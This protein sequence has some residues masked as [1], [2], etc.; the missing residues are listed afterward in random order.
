VSALRLAALRARRKDLFTN[1]WE[2]LDQRSRLLGR[3][4]ILVD[5]GLA[6]AP[7]PERPFDPDGLGIDTRRL[8]PNHSV[9][10]AVTI[11]VCWAD[12]ESHPYPGQVVPE[13]AVLDAYGSLGGRPSPHTSA[14]LRHLLAAAG[15][16]VWVD[17]TVRLGPVVAGWGDPDIAA[18]RRVEHLLPAPFPAGIPW[19]RPTASLTVSPLTGPAPTGGRLRLLSARDQEQVL[20]AVAALENADEPLPASRFSALADPA[21]KAAVADCLAVGG[22]RLVEQPG[23]TWLSGYDDRIASRLA[24]EG[25]GVLAPVDAAVLTLVLLHTVAIPRASG[26]ASTSRW[27]DAQP[28]TIDELAKNRSLSES[29]IRVSLRRLKDAGILRP[30]HRPE[31][32][33]GPQFERLT[34][35]QSQRLW[36]DLIVT[37]KPDSPEAR[38][39][40]FRRGEIT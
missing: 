19:E 20:D 16:V 2:S 29:Q 13:S 5:G 28:V 30:G 15:F 10:L 26:R 22:R 14:A 9:V 34:P 18:L 12:R 33:P 7:N 36:E 8:A 25:I 38:R 31:I 21:L 35:A 37:T 40:L 4:V 32:V 11:G 3:S 23:S 24:A 27:T 17:R 39:I 1:D 6:L